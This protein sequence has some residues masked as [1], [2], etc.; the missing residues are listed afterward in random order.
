VERVVVIPAAGS[1]SRL[2]ASLPKLLVPV[3]GRPMIEHLL[4]LYA[5]Q[6]GRVILI[7]SPSA[8]E[9]VSGAMRTSIPPVS[10]VLQAQPTGML[11]AILLAREQVEAWRPRR[12]L[13]TWCDQV[14]ISPD[15]V[16]EVA[17]HARESPEPSLVLPTCHKD[18][19]YVHLH[20]DACGRIVRVLH[21]REGDQMPETGESDAGVFDL[22]AEAYGEWLPRYARAPEIGARTGERNFVPFVAFVAERGRVVT[23]PC[24]EPEEAIGINTPDELARI[25]GHLRAR[26][27]R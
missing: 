3:N 26:Q 13:I 14:A 25:E 19:P 7:V 16:A 15:T 9:T 10:L 22:S 21:R 27:S 5:K 18:E 20:R 1:G 23:V 4:A 12:I 24:A 8:V 6:A 2:G 17:R 11:D